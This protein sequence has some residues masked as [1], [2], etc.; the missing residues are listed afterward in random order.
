MEYQIS[1]H[2]KERYAERI[3]DK[4]LKIEVTAFVV[5]HDQKIIEDINKMIEFGE[6]IYRGK[7]T[8]SIHSKTNIITVFVKDCWIILVDAQKYNVIT[9]YKVDFGLG[10]EFNKI[11]MSKM[12]EKVHTINEEINDLKIAVGL[13]NNN[14]QDMIQENEAQINEFRRFIKNLESLNDSYRE[15]IKTGEVAIDMKNKELGDL[16]N[17]IV[18]KKEF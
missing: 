14:Y 18:G 17:S 11:Y 5:E 1:K 9:L 15:I 13:E 2:A 6:C 16:I 7:Q 3:M 10:E 8:D 4:D 12:L